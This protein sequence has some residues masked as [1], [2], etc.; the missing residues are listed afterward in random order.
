M[1]KKFIISW[2]AVFVAWMVGSMIIHGMWLG[3]TYAALGDLFRPEDQQMETFPVMIAAHVIMAAAFV[4]IYL[5]GLEDSPW[6]AQGVRY[7]VAIALLAPAPMYM[8]YYAVQPLPADMVV[9]Q[10]IGDGILLVV[11][12][13]LTAFVNKPPATTSS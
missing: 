10:I 9:K 12:G 1:N 11:L 13:V 8:I 3:E 7:G 2:L 4:W 6:L 5:R